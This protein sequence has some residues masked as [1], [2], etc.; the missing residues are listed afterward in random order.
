MGGWAARVLCPLGP[1][2]ALRVGDV[3]Y[4]VLPAVDV[5]AWVPRP[6]DPAWEHT[7]LTILAGGALSAWAAAGVAGGTAAGADV[8]GLLEI[9]GRVPTA[10]APGSQLLLPLELVALLRAVALGESP[11]EVL[12]RVADRRR[13]GSRHLA[14]ASAP[15]S[16]LRLRPAGSARPRRGVRNLL[17]RYLQMSWEELAYGGHQVADPAPFLVRLLRH[18]LLV[19]QAEVSRLDPDHWPAWKPPYLLSP[20]AAPE[21]LAADA[22]HGGRVDQLPDYAQAKLDE[23]Y[24]PD[25]RVLAIRPSVPRRPRGRARAER[26][27]RRAARGRVA[28]ARGRGGAGHLEPPDRPVDHRRRDSPP[29]P[30]HRPWGA[31]AAR[32]VRMGRRP[33]A[34][35]G[36]DAAHHRRAAPCAG[37]GAGAGGSR[38][39]RPRSARRRRRALAD[40]RPLGPDPPGGKARR[41]RTAGRPPQRGPRPRDRAARRRPGRRPDPAPEIPAASRAGRT[42]RLRR[43]A[44]PRRAIRATSPRRSAHSTI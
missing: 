23:Q 33:L 34:G 27:G 14:G 29:S 4:G 13:R 6:S 39:A 1:Y 24:P 43:V 20:N 16:G 2:A 35:H 25:P 10:R 19:T 3:P 8:D 5:P 15:L 37:A 28:R 26:L 40:H 22:S 36:P 31:A 7:L 11:Q 41:R 30:A 44:G 18:S 9:I 32:R 12:D 17:R 21:Q 42:P 38:A